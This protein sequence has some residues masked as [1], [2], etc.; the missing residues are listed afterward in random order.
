MFYLSNLNIFILNSEVDK[1]LPIALADMGICFAIYGLTF[2][3]GESLTDLMYG[4][5]ISG[6]PVKADWYHKLEASGFSVFITLSFY[7]LN[8]R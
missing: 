1:V 7:K 4:V 3:N 5:T 6:D 2:R 8:L